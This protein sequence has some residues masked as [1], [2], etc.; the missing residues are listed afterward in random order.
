LFLEA[1]EKAVKDS[2]AKF[3]EFDTFG[4]QDKKKMRYLYLQ[5]VRRLGEELETKGDSEFVERVSGS[6]EEFFTNF[7]EKNVCEKLLSPED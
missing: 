2:M 3:E 5:L 7:Y 4:K 6:I 1:M